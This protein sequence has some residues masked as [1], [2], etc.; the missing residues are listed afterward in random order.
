MKVAL[1]KGKQFLLFIAESASL[2]IMFKIDG[3]DS[4]FSVFL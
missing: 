3:I 4:F 1:Q 2:N